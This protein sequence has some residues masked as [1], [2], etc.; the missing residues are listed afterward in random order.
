MW[1]IKFRP[2]AASIVIKDHLCA[3]FADDHAFPGKLAILLVKVNMSDVLNLPA[4]GRRQV[5]VEIQELIDT[6]FGRGELVQVNADAAFIADDSIQ[7]AA[8]WQG[9]PYLDRQFC[10]CHHFRHVGRQFDLG[11][12]VD[13]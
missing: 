9:Q 10:R 3:S 6:Y 13:R 12:L 7:G 4:I 2:D 8:R 11:Q 5:P 1:P